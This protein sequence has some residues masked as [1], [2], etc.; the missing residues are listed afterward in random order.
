[1]LGIFCSTNFTS[2]EEYKKHL[3]KRNYK[4]A[5][6]FVLGIV[7]FVVAI[8]AQYVWKVS[9]SENIMSTYMG[10]GS[11]LIAASVILFVKNTILLKDEERMKKARIESSDERNQYISA[12]ATK[13]ALGVLLIGIYF[14]MLIGGLW[15]SI[16]AEIMSLLICLF[17][18]V[19]CIAYKI[20][21]RLL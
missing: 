7:T 10:V 16:L 17:V 3:K 18:V 13:I 2:N 19:Y 4:L 1:M 9:V 5:G 6:L 11:G 8:L 12:K 20:L 14:V 15:N 21:I